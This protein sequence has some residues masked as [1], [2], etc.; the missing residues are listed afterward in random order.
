VHPG[1]GSEKKN[2]PRERF[3]EL[4]KRL[5]KAGRRVRVIVGEVEEEKWGDQEIALFKELADVRRP[6]DYVELFAELKSATAVVANDSGPGHLAGI[7]GVKTVSIFG[8]TDADVW[9]PL[10]PRV[11]V[12]RASKLQEVTVD[13]VYDAV[14]K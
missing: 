7:M 6:K 13:E 11:K 10:G 9:R 2:W 12:V 14:A 5:R 1:S 3:V 4:V 8:A